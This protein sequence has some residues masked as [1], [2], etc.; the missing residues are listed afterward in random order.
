MRA[1]R[2]SARACTERQSRNKVQNFTEEAKAVA[3]A[4]YNEYPERYGNV[5]RETKHAKE[6]SNEERERA[7]EAKAKQNR[8]AAKKKQLVTVDAYGSADEYT[9]MKEQLYKNK[10]I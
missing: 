9:R 8:K 5:C 2:P 1:W 4:I 3:E 6:R 10:Q 7:L